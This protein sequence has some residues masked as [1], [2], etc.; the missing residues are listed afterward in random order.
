[1]RCSSKSIIQYATLLLVTALLLIGN[2][3]FVPSSF[4]DYRPSASEVWNTAASYVSGAPAPRDD[5]IQSAVAGFRSLGV[6][7]AAT[8]TATSAAGGS[9]G[10]TVGAGGGG[11]ARRRAA[12]DCLITKWSAFWRVHADGSRSHVGHPTADCTVDGALPTPDLELFP[13]AHGGKGSYFLDAAQSAAACKLAA[14]APPGATLG[15]AAE[16][17]A[18][19]SLG[20]GDSLLGQ[21]A[22]A[23]AAAAGAVGKDAAGAMEVVGGAVGA[24]ARPAAAAAGLVDDPLVPLNG[25]GAGPSTGWMERS[26]LR[27]NSAAKAAFATLDLRPGEVADRPGFATPC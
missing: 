13:K 14:C 11:T 1:M 10:G 20:D 6:P 27:F 5:A 9:G 4:Q 7:A 22:A 18:E 23:V 16:L 24:I 12:S 25:W 26:N 19:P 8:P 2:G 15:S 17:L 3:I 21:A